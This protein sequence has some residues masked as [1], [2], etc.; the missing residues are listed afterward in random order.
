MINEHASAMAIPS[1]NKNL[2]M[3][4]KIIETLSAES[5]KQLVPAYY[6]VALKI[7]YSR[8]EES[9][10]MLD[11]IFEGVVYDFGLLYNIPTFDIYQEILVNE[12][13]PGTFASLVERTQPRAET[14]LQRILDLYDEID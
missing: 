8:D 7:K 5:H 14:A 4:G 6:E 3:T 11:L 9:V 12:R 13:D 2:E 1:Y 10:R